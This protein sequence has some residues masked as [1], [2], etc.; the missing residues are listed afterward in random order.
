[1]TRS[2]GRC[3]G[4]YLSARRVSPAFLPVLISEQQTVQAYVYIYEGK[5][6]VP[7][8]VGLAQ[9]AAMVVS[10]SGTSGACFDYVRKTFE[11]LASIGVDDLASDGALVCGPRP[12]DEPSLGLGMNLEVIRHQRRE[13][14][15]HFHIDHMIKRCGGDVTNHWTIKEKVVWRSI[16]RTV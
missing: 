15:R 14:V 11:D 16:L 1:M 12:Q 8:Q 5:N 2:R 7:P 3:G 6:I 13:G 9:R 4:I 10:A